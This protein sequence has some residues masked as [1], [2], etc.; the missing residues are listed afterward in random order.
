LAAKDYKA[1]EFKSFKEAMDIFLSGFPL[2]FQSST[3]RDFERFDKD[4]ILDEAK[5]AFPVGEME[6]LLRAGKIQQLS[7]KFSELFSTAEITSEIEV[8]RF[9]DFIE[10]EENCKDFT[11]FLVPVLYGDEFADSFHEY[12]KFLNSKREIRTWPTATYFLAILQPKKHVFL[13]P[14]IVQH[15]AARLGY[16][17]N[18]KSEISAE[19]YIQFKN[20]AKDLYKRMRPYG[21]QDYMDVH[22]FMYAIAKGGYI[23]EAEDFRRSFSMRK[24]E[25]E[26][27]IKATYLNDYYAGRSTFIAK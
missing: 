10:I 19:T 3:Y 22:C 6:R 1:P 21:A 11:S 13:K 5:R 15:C 18:Y 26:K 12:A 23:E 17:L 16:D 7:Q 2:P 20:M 24:M 14:T 4:R 25:K 8:S 27:A 9:R